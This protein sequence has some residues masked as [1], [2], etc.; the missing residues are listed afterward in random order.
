MTRTTVAAAMFLAC[1]TTAQPSQ[2]EAP[3]PYAGEQ[4]RA[5]KALSAKEVD[6][7]TAGRGMG[8]AKPAEL[9]GYPGPRHALDMAAQMHLAVSQRETLRASMTRMT[10]R[11]KAIGAEILAAERELNLAFADRSIDAAKL[12]ESTARI[13]SKQ[14]ELR[15]VH[16]QAH[17]ETA[18]ELSSAQIK[19]YDELRGYGGT[20]AVM[21]A[22]STHVGHG[23][24]KH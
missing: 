4:R 8:L 6:D 24:G 1:F 17:L 21:G 19:R 23:V 15:T 11:A 22:E 16:L 2:A 14:G 13:G 12:A 20:D 3:S 18:A 10:T 7:L 5:I 9:N